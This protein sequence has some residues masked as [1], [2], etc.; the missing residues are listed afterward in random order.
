MFEFTD[1][2]ELSEINEPVPVSGSGGH[3]DDAERIPYQLTLAKDHPKG[4]VPITIKDDDK[5]LTKFKEVLELVKNEKQVL[6]LVKSMIGEE[7]SFDF[8]SITYQLPQNSYTEHH[9]Q[10]HDNN[11]AAA[12]VEHHMTRQEDDVVDEKFKFLI[13]NWYTA[14]GFEVPALI[15]VTDDLTVPNMPTC[16]QRAKAK[17]IIYHIPKEFPGLP[18]KF[19]S[20]ED[21]E[22]FDIPELD[23]VAHMELPTDDF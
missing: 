16:L 19:P 15:F 14:A 1:E 10:K 17:L 12:W 21:L 13:G 2:K 23:F 20:Q 6:I 8:K 22:P 18:P 11:S 4:E 9:F 3:L 7:G 5:N